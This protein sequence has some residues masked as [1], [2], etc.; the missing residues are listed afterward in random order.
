MPL[1]ASSR[2]STALSASTATSASSAR[3]SSGQL[4]E[5]VTHPSGRVAWVLVFPHPNR[6]PPHVRESR[7]GVRIALNVPRELRLPVRAVRARYLRVLR[8]A[9][10]EAAVEEDGNALTREG[11]INTDEA[12]T[13]HSDRI[14]AAEAEPSAMKRRTEDDLRPG[15]PLPVPLHHSGSGRGGGMR[16][17]VCLAIRARRWLGDETGCQ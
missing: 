10:P 16:I 13:R 12:T 15:V 14:V 2:T 3:S 5:R 1:P 6:V 4:G 8:T 11:D 7:V 9:V 17:T